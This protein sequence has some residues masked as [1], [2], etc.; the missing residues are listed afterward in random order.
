MPPVEN[1]ITVKYAMNTQ[2]KTG[3]FF[4]EAVKILTEVDET[5]AEVTNSRRPVGMMPTYGRVVAAT[6]FRKVMS[7]TLRFGECDGKILI[8]DKSRVEIL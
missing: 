7:E 5:I 2:F 4:L 1:I 6:M 8:F 3:Q